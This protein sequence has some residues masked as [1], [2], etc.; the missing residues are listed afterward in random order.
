MC[1]RDSAWF[2]SSI[3][4][5]QHFAKAIFRSIENNTY[6][7]RAANKGVSV[8]INNNGVVIKRLGPNEVGNIELN[9]PLIN[10][11]I[12]NKNDLIFFILLFTYLSIFLIFKNKN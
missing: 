12:K 9:V 4:P 3:G 1:I 8:F 5:H 11:N 6:L 7:V 10:N 2:G